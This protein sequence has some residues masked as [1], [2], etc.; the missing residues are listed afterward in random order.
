VFDLASA[1][2]AGLGA[3]NLIAQVAPA[4]TCELECINA[5]RDALEAARLVGS[6]LVLRGFGGVMQIA[7]SEYPWSLVAERGKQTADWYVAELR[8]HGIDPNEFGVSGELPP[9]RGG[10]LEFHVR[11][12]RLPTFR[13][14]AP[15]QEDATWCEAHF[16]TARDLRNKSAKFAFALEA[17]T[18]WRFA[19]DPRSAIARLWAGIEAIFGVNAELVYRLSTYS[20]SL[21]HAR[22]Q[23]RT[24]AYASTKK[25]YGVR[26]KAVH[27]SDV[28]KAKLD[29]GVADS[30]ALLRA[31]LLA[32]LDRGGVPT[33]D[34]LDQLVFE[35]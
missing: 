21:L 6:L 16:E 32:C 12:I 28:S 30:Y 18:D 34:E 2:A 14:E 4:C 35:R 5:G 7:S 22:G 23:A 33:E 17:A 25:L 26:S 27:G 20:A 13:R 10:V 15:S 19:A 24:A 11:G 31:V 8:R 1:G 29:E 9:F 3:W